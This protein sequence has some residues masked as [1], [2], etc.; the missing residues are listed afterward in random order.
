MYR[1]KT[2]GVV[3]PAYNEQGL[4]GEVIDTMPAFVDRVYAVDD[5][6]SDGTWEEILAYADRANREWRAGEPIADGGIAFDRRVVPVRHETNSGVGA[7]IQTG[8]AR[9]AE[10]GLDVVAV[11]NGD[12]QMD[13]DY[14]D[15]IIDPVVNGITGY[16]KANRL[17]YRDYRD[18][19]SGFRFFGN[20]VLSLLTKVASGYW[21]ITDPQNGYTA[22][23]GDV[24][25][26]LDL[27]Q[28]YDDYGFLNSLLVHLNA[29]GV[30]VADVAVPAV[31]G[32]ESSTIRY[33]KF[34]PRLSALLLR[35]FLWRLKTKYVVFDFHPLVLFYLLGV[36][37]LLGGL[38]GTAAVGVGA[39]AA[40]AAGGGVLA[41]L[42]SFLSLLV[43]GTA[44]ATG[45]LLD[46]HESRGLEL[47]R[48]DR[49]AENGS[50]TPMAGVASAD[51]R[52]HFE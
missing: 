8:Y 19:M 21:K 32:D 7:A 25:S 10:D 28:L 3:V 34:I 9:A 12:A 38:G 4:V 35:C 52:D 29:R 40:T 41:A 44:L 27:D 49:T 6:S 24:L 15:R 47:L 30:R 31:Y 13:P 37:G 26:E 1:G 22:V 43:G 2:V 18:G 16:A 45:M 20:S 23:S 11:M 51:R 39:S 5:R 17:V 46:M 48:Y 33:S 42:L 50:L 14:L 36:V